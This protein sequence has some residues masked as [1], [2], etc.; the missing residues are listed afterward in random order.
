MPTMM[1]YIQNT[2]PGSTA[3]LPGISL[4][5][6]LTKEGLPVG[7]ALDTLPGRDE[8]LLAI[9]NAIEPLFGVLAPPSE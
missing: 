9:A 4:P 8:K 2:D 3:G 6:G 1:T 7:L 5:I